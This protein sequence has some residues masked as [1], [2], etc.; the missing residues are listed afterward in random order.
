MSLA[1]TI[2]SWETDIYIIPWSVSI[3]NRWWFSEL[4]VWWD[5]LI[6]CRVCSFFR[7]F[8]WFRCQHTLHPQQNSAPNSTPL[9][10]NS[11]QP[12]PSPPL[13]AP[14][15]SNKA[16]II[17][18][19]SWYDK[20]PT[21]YRVFLDI[22]FGGFSRRISEP[23]TILRGYPH[24]SANARNRNLYFWSDLP[25]LQRWPMCASLS[26]RCDFLQKSGGV[27]G[28][29]SFWMF[30]FLMIWCWIFFWMFFLFFYFE[31]FSMFL[32]C[33][34]IWTDDLMLGFYVIF[35]FERF[36]L[37]DFWWFDV[38]F[39]M[40]ISHDFGWFFELMFWRWI[41]RMFLYDLFWLDDSMLDL[42]G[43][44]FFRPFLQRR[45]THSPFFWL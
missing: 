43:D 6:S 26:S 29:I 30:F 10:S 2:I 14:P 13:V 41:F 45:K 24:G 7:I 12:T 4:P 44:S 19:T 37:D 35:F 39:V 34:D 27:V 28:E 25:P 17:R 3:L 15:L 5:M 9:K 18:L 23:S 42:F 32:W 33:F 16:L 20:Y 40:M 1:G 31:R 11:S 36:F 38:E 8:L 21:I 22:P